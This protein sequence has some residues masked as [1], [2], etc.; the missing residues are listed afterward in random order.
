[1]KGIPRKVKLLGK[2]YDL[3]DCTTEMYSQDILGRATPA[4]L[5]V[6]YSTAPAEDQLR[7]TLLHE[8][9]HVI[10]YAMNLGLAETQVVCL[11]TGII[12]LLKNNPK[13]K[14]VILGE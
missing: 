11:T 10:S 7:D 5:L 14:T 8:F 1:M 2:T 6:Q 9:L 13:L 4:Q 3:K 12:D